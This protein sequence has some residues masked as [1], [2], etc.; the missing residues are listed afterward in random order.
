MRQRAQL[1]APPGRASDKEDM[2]EASGAGAAS[3]AAAVLQATAG[4]ATCSV[5]VCYNQALSRGP[6]LLNGPVNRHCIVV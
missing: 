2:V 6:L 1:F 4:A 3:T 5:P